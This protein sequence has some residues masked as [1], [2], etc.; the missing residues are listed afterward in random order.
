[1]KVFKLKT[2]SSLM[3]AGSAVFA[4]SAYAALTGTATATVNFQGASSANFGW[5][6]EAGAFTGGCAHANCF[7]QQGTVVGIVHD[8]LDEGGAHWHGVGTATDKEAQYHTDDTGVYVRLADLTKF[9]LQSINLN[10]GGAEGDGSGLGNFRIYG[11][12]NALNPGILSA[13]VGTPFV[14]PGD[15][16]TGDP[17]IIRQNPLDPSGGNVAP[18]A[19][20]SFANDGATST[21]TLAQLLAADA[22]WGNIGAF[23]ITFEGFNH[24]PTESYE[25]GSYPAW[26][27]RVDDIVLG[28]AIP[29]VSNVPLPGTVWLFGSA[30]AG[31]IARRKKAAV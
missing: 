15:P 19:S 20:Y 31:F 22:D 16:T 18:I 2:L 9:S 24:S 11:Y 6:N 12:A 1:M 3:L 4:G 30:L 14:I 29:P 27:L 7:Q 21:L 13:N 17:D 23:W 25:I 5:G 28:A 26:D 10:T 8:P